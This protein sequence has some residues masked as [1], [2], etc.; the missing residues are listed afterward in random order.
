MVVMTLPL[1]S[2][3]QSSQG[4]VPAENYDDVKIWG[5]LLPV[6]DFY[7]LET[8]DLTTL[9]IQPYGGHNGFIDGLYLKGWYEQQMI[10]IFNEVARDR[11]ISLG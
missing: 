11:N 6:E 4:G 7:Q 9:I 3:A 5:Y 10:M 1:I 8:N 2:I